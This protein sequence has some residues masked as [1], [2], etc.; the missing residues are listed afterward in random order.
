MGHQAGGDGIHHH[1]SKYAHEGVTALDQHGLVAPLKDMS[2]ALVSAI[3]P[4]AIGRI[5][6]LQQSGNWPLSRLQQQMPMI[7][8]QA[9]P[10]TS[11]LKAI[12][13]AGED[14]QISLAVTI[15]TK[16]G[17]LRVAAG[18]YVVDHAGN[19]Q[20]ERTSHATACSKRCACRGHAK[21]LGILEGW[22]SERALTATNKALRHSDFCDGR[23]RRTSFAPGLCRGRLVQRVSATMRAWSGV[24]SRLPNESADA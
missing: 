5:D 12:E 14:L 7:A 6:L 13:P 23:I 20:S 18:D 9:V 10:E 3:E 22:N 21:L 8:E 15:I 4:L 17:L 24:G 2:D 16:D 11:N 19:V 1:I